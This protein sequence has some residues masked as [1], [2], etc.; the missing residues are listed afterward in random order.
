MADIA[1][2]PVRGRIAEALLLLS[3]SYKNESNPEGTISISRDDL[4]S[5]VGTVKET[6]IRVLKDLKEEKLIE[7][8]NHDI[9]IIDRKGLTHVCELYD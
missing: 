8:K 2:K 3:Q 1:Y 7:T 6:A 4:A 5:Y 9:H